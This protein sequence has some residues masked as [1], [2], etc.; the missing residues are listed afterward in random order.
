MLSNQCQSTLCTT[1]IVGMPNGCGP[2]MQIFTKLANVPLLFLR[3][4]KLE[5]II[6][7]DDPYFQGDTYALM[8][9]SL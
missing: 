1:N 3:E 9:L 4:E 5:L 8:L 7:V 2:A 6:Y